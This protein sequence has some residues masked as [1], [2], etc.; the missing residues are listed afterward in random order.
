MKKYI[1]LIIAT[2]TFTSCKKFLEE[3]PLDQVISANF[4]ATEADVEASVDGIYNSA[5]FEAGSGLNIIFPLEHLSDDGGYSTFTNFVAER[6][7]IDLHTFTSANSI[8]G[9]MWSRSYTVI[10]RANNVIKYAVDSAK[11]RSTVIR[12]AQAQARFFRAFYHFRLVQ[13]FGDVPLMLEPAEVQLGNIQPKRTAT[14]AVYESVINDLKYAKEHLA[15]SYAYASEDGGRVTSA[16]AKTLLGKVYLTMA[17]FP[18]NDNTGYQLAIDELKDLIDNKASYNLDLNP[19]YAKIFND[20]VAVKQADKERIYFIRGTSGLPNSLAA[21]NRMGWLYRTF[22]AT[23]PTKDYANDAPVATRVYDTLIDLRR[24]KSVNAFSSANVNSA[25]IMKYVVGDD[26]SDDLIL[27]RYADVLMMTAEALIEIG[28]TTNL[29]NAL[30]IINNIRRTHGGA[31]LRLIT[32]TDQNDLRTKLRQ[33]RRR[34]FAFEAHRWFDLKRWDIMIPTIK[35]SLANY[36]NNPLS[37]YDYIDADPNKFK[38][39]PIPIQEIA[40]NPNMT[41]NPGF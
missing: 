28:G 13:M 18:L 31:T 34:E 1:F 37:Q 12:Q 4:Y 40:N 30:T 36:Y 15:K 21:F 17:G 25:L 7:Q 19:V 14:R 23:C 8:V 5:R 41:Q 16:A 38:V 33:E 24:T 32:Y 9:Q 11:V 35:A 3:K 39:L 29:N 6:Q 20:T 22:R 27:L 2:A 10:N 26:A